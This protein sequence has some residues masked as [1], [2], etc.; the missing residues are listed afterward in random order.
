MSLKLKLRNKIWQIEGTVKLADGVKKRV[1]QTTGY[2]TAMKTHAEKELSD[3]LSDII[4]GKVTSTRADTVDDIAR[5]YLR[6][7]DKDLSDTSLH[8]LS[9]LT[10]DF[11]KVLIKD[12]TLR[13]LTEWYGEMDIAPSS[14]RRHMTT[15]NAMLEY[16]TSQG[17]S[18]VPTWRLSKPTVD[19]S[20]C[21]WLTE[22]ERDEFISRSDPAARGI[23]ALFFYTGCRLSEGFRLRGRDLRDGQVTVWSRK[24]KAKKKKVR[25][26]PILHEVAV[27]MKPSYSP[28]EL[29]FPD[30]NGNEW[31]R[32]E[33]YRYFNRVVADLS[34]EDFV[35]HDMRHTYASHL[36]QK[37]VNLVVLQQLLGH[38]TLEMVKRYAHLAPNNLTEAA[39]VLSKVA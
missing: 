12:L 28:S 32:Q 22:D 37:G 31:T 4:S 6:K 9:Q 20:R 26:L 21:R 1:R 16:A 24:G 14:I 3:L 10:R 30:P 17:V 35:A 18:S 2:P 7:P 15:V 39:Q 11:G 25:Q 19:D 13:Q 29:I 36:V 8:N 33:F 23:L 5:L 34:I 38:E 27:H